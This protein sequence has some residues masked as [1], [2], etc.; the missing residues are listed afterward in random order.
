MLGCFHTYH[1]VDKPQTPKFILLPHVPFTSHT[2]TVRAYTSLLPARTTLKLSFS[3]R[4]WQDGRASGR[5]SNNGK[6][7]YVFHMEVVIL[8]RAHKRSC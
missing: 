6:T 5:A 1:Y 8:T 2:L 4:V 3:V 7:K